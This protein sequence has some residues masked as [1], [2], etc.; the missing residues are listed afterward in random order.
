MN[1]FLLDVNGNEYQNI[2]FIEGLPFTKHDKSYSGNWKWRMLEGQLINVTNIPFVEIVPGTEL[3]NKPDFYF[4]DGLKIILNE[5]VKRVLENEINPNVCQFVPLFLL[6]KILGV[7]ENVYIVNPLVTV[8]CI[9]EKYSKYK[10]KGVVDFIIEPVLEKKK[11]PDL[12]IFLILENPRLVIITQNIY[13][14]LNYNNFKGLKIIN[15]KSSDDVN[16]CN[17]MKK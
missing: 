7:V 16:L 14:L 1:Y 12:P 6:D 4:L 2:C 10:K 9:S 13:E 5:K 8:D 15:V 3:K 11:I 17:E